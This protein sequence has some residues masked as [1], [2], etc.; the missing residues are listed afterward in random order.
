MSASVLQWEVPWW[1][2]KSTREPRWH[3]WFRI[4]AWNA[5][6]HT[7]CKS[8][9]NQSDVCTQYFLEIA[10]LIWKCWADAEIRW[11]SQEKQ[12]SEQIQFFRLWLV[13]GWG[14]SSVLREHAPSHHESL[15]RKLRRAAKPLKK[16]ESW[17]IKQSNGEDLSW[18]MAFKPKLHGSSVYRNHCNLR[19]ED[20]ISSNS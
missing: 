5:A 18:S 13:N 20:A 1:A 4:S 17:N 16:D 10:W 12:S 14:R 19:V 9:R 15:S 8:S 11:K 2:F 7:T 3:S 6:G